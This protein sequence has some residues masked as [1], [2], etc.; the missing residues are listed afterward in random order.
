M[1]PVGEKGPGR[2]NPPNWGK[3]TQGKGPPREQ[4]SPPIRKSFWGESSSQME[5]EARP[6]GR[7]IGLLQEL[8]KNLTGFTSGAPF[9]PPPMRMWEET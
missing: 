7:P 2:A 4:D 9:A 8:F 1:P 5:A 6:A 3:K